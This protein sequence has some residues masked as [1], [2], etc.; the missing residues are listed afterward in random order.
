MNEITHDYEYYNHPICIRSYLSG[1]DPIKIKDITKKMVQWKPQV[2]S[3]GLFIESYI[4]L[5]RFRYLTFQIRHYHF[6][7]IGY[8]IFFSKGFE[9]LLNQNRSLY[10]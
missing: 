4:I 3:K 1:V 10:F 9:V 7:L 6:I 5:G 8:I 2:E